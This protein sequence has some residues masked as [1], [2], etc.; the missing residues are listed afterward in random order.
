MKEITYVLAGRIQDEETGNC[1][2]LSDVKVT[3]I[4]LQVG[5]IFDALKN[6]PGS[7]D[8]SVSYEADA[9]IFDM[10]K[11]ALEQARSDHSDFVGDYEDPDISDKMD[12]ELARIRSN[13][14][15]HIYPTET[16]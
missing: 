7:P 1:V 6:L 3:G 15:L 16:E 9:K 12:E 8:V 10:G 11:D 14:R 4:P 13:W 5:M 2:V